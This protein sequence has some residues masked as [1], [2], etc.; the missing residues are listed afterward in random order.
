MLDELY[1]DMEEGAEKSLSV[2]RKEIARVRTGRASTAILE[3]IRVDYY[4]VPTPLNQVA[5][6]SVPDAR[7]IVVQPWEKSVIQDVE[8]AIAAADLGLNPVSDGNVIRLPIPPLNEERRKEIV[9]QVKKMAE[10]SK[11]AIRNI[12]REFNDQLKKLEKGKKITEDELHRSLDKT[13]EITNEYIAKVDEVLGHK[14][15]EI[16]EI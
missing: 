1:L 4:N 2:F 3:S 15:K 6:I 9:R 8:K 14:E 11:I 16:L 12:R 10:D 7:L 5:S 13:Q